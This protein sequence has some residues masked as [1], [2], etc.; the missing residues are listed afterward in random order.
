[1]EA[2][3]VAAPTT[4]EVAIAATRPRPVA[5]GA[6]RYAWYVLF[7]LCFANFFNA[8]DRGIVTLLLQP[9]E[10]EL[11]A[12]DTE[13]GL[14]TGFA[15]VL[16]YSALGVP[17]AR[18]SDRGVRRDI[19][20]LGLAVWSVMT[21]ASGLAG[22]FLQMAIARAGVGIGEA[23][24]VPPSSSLITDYFPQE[25]WSRAMSIFQVCTPLGLVVGAPIA[26]IVTQLYGWRAAFFVVGIPGI[27]LAIL[28]RLTVREPP[29]GAGASSGLVAAAVTAEPSFLAALAIMFR[30][31]AFTLLFIGQAIGGLAMG[32]QQAWGPTY[33]VRTHH[34]SYAEVGGVVGPV[35]GVLGILGTL[36]GGYVSAWAVR[37][38]R[39]DR[40]TLLVP[41]Y[42][43]VLTIPLGAFFI[44]FDNLTLVVA[45][46][47]IQLFFIMFRAGPYLSLPL[48]L[49]PA[50]IR[51]LTASVM[52]IAGSVIGSGFGPLLVGW[53][54]DAMQGS[55][56]PAEALR[57]ALLANPV[58]FLVST[59]F[60]F[61]TFWCLPRHTGQSRGDI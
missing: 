54:S 49:V 60:F 21:A 34:M 56:G 2:G 28:I 38:W 43:S 16:F 31:P 13:M 33:L 25:K 50:E 10:T 20:A 57:F 35:F 3:G 27:L 58:L 18:W 11:N 42:A 37:R 22:S 45:S 26:G 8:I 15:F 30:Q 12:S 44:W 5:P 17:L 39:D 40:W 19:L 36:A 29:R 24:G 1:M 46:G 48:E 52:L 59:V 61:A 53:L 7:V 47:G 9:I 41:A 6:A 51:S 4:S 55:L 32:T 14:L 23:A